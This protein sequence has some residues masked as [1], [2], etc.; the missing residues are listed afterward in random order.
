MYFV[1]CWVEDR[2]NA[3]VNRC[4]HEHTTF[5]DALQCLEGSNGF[6]RVVENGN[7]RSLTRVEMADFKRAVRGS[8]NAA[9]AATPP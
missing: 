8:A 7:E 4:D 6:L 5:N 1:V 9:P 2:A 3:T